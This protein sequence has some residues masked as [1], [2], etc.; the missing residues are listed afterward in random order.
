V[1]SPPTYPFTPV[2]EYFSCF[3]LWLL[4][5]RG[6][7]QS[8]PVNRVVLGLLFWKCVH[9]LIVV[10]RV[11]TGK[12]CKPQS[13]FSYYIY[14]LYFKFFPRLDHPSCSFPPPL[15]LFLTYSAQSII[16]LHRLMRLP[17]VHCSRSTPLCKTLFTNHYALLAYL[18]YILKHLWSWQRS[19][20]Q[21]LMPRLAIFTPCALVQIAL[22]TGSMRQWV[23][24]K[25]SASAGCQ[26]N[27]H[28]CTSQPSAP[29]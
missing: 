4:R 9:W 29:A 2:L 11:F 1:E 18:Q 20:R 13:V 7:A 27:S 28:S 19:T 25:Y 22:W 23:P 24:R 21:W 16:N 14:F 15:T 17:C 6:S 5:A 10:A 12:A 3:L 26:N 8:C